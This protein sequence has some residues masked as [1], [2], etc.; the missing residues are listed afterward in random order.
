VTLAVET[1]DKGDIWYVD[2]TEVNTTCGQSVD[3]QVSTS[4]EQPSF[5]W[6][7]NQAGEHEYG[8]LL[9]QWF[10]CLSI[11]RIRLF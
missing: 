8:V 6:A 3:V 7:C 2:W 10:T 5:L 11:F 9:Q 1:S 4:R